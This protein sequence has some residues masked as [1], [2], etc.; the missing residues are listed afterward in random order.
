M[1]GIVYREGQFM[2]LPRRAALDLASDGV[3]ELIDQG[4]NLMFELF[5]SNARQ[6]IVYAQRHTVELRHPTIEVEH[7]LLGVLSLNDGVA[8][9]ALEAFG[10]TLAQ[11]RSAIVCEL[12]EGSKP[13]P[14]SLPF[15]DAA[16]GVLEA[17]VREST[18]LE[19]AHPYVGSEHIL[20]ALLSRAS[21]T[22]VAVG[23]VGCAVDAIRSKTLDLLREP[24]GI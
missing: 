15:S 21:S 16:K 17:S 1:D 8:H 20:L 14:T 5:T 6:V 9:D 12:G 3:V 10:L 13:S 2:R 22:G 24:R 23:M 7:L 18:A 19:H 4:A 11:A